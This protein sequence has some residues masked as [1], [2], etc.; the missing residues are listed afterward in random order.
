MERI[1]VRFACRIE[2]EMNLAGFEERR[3]D[4]EK[5]RGR[6]GVNSCRVCVPD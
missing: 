2:G 5:E 1:P 6:V 4:G 3:R